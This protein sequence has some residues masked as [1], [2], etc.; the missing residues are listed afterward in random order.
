MSHGGYVESNVM[1]MNCLSEAKKMGVDL[2]VGN[3]VEFTLLS[4]T[5]PVIPVNNQGW[6]LTSATYSGNPAAIVMN[7]IAEAIETSGIELQMYHS[8][9]GMGQVR[10]P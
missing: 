4:S 1:L 2:L 3:E 5:N 7:E 6:S 9:G 10:E 8:E